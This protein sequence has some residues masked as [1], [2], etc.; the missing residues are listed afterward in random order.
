MTFSEFQPRHVLCILGP[1]GTFAELCRSIQSAIDDFAHQFEIDGVYSQETSDNRMA[2]SF[3]VS[4]DRV[5][6]G[7]VTEKDEEA[8]LEHGCVIYVLGPHMDAENAIEISANALRLVV[9]ALDCGATAAKGESAGIAHGAAR[10]RQIGRDA[11]HLAEREKLARLCRLAFTKRPLSD[12]DFL[13]S[14]GFHL[15]GLPE[16]Y[17][18]RGISDDDLTLSST[19][20]RVADELFVHGVEKILTHYSAMLLPVDGYDEDDFKYNP[21]GAIYLNVDN[22]PASRSVEE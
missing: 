7:A 18:P 5:H 14:V 11:E 10:W 12:G 15:V 4:W 6:K 8:V 21:Y 16:I 17:V 9:H 1:H 22:N 20:D 19:I 3:D 13:C 2:Q